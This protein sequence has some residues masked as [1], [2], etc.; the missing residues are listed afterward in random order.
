[1]ISASAIDQPPTARLGRARFA[2]AGA[3]LGSRAL[4]LVAGVLGAL[5]P[6]AAG[7]LSFDPGRASSSLG[8][9]GN[10]LGA[11]ALRWDSIWYLRIA[12]HG[13][14]TAASTAFF[15]LYP[16]LLRAVGTVTGSYVAAG[17][18]ISW[19]AFAAALVLL[20]RLSEAELGGEAALA[21]VVLL[22]F[23]PLSLFF[24]AIY[25]EALF[26]ALA[27][28][29]A[30]AARRERWA[31]AGA[32]A[33]LAAA[34]RIT[35]VLLVVLALPRWRRRGQA[36]FDRRRLWLLAAPAALLA[37]LGWLTVAGYSPLAP[38]S[39]QA[40]AAHGHR[41][42]GPLV[43]V[44][45]ATRAAVGGLGG[46]IGHARPLLSPGSLGSPFAPGAESVYLFV[47]L[48]LAAGA[49]AVCFRRLPPAYG[50]FALLALLVAISSP[51]AGQPLKSL[52]RYVLT[53]FPL[54]MAAGAWLAERR[55]LWQAT[56]VSACLLAFFTV[57]FATWT[58]VA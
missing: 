15:P 3:L 26:L 21:T 56:A 57:E 16:L 28:A 55:W 2:M 6:R 12:E 20:R 19:S 13:Y 30:Y 42:V 23:A 37:Y 25:T 39:A 34:T 49:L 40:S 24:T 7:W 4:V 1:M 38:F 27:V 47:V 44:A 32:L 29:S 10:L 36:R 22:A 48:I 46:L 17:V 31:L 51:V 14:S 50:A 53:I 8:A 54:W 5:L 45:Q 33:A 18:L 52:D 35:G 41:F 43:A 9:V 11:S 58:F